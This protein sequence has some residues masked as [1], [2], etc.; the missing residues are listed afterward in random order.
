MTP[1]SETRRS[2]RVYGG[3]LSA[4]A[5]VLLGI[6][7]FAFRAATSH[8]GAGSR[9][10]RFSIINGTETLKVVSIE[11]GDGLYFLTLRNDSPKI[12]TGYAYRVAPQSDEGPILNGHVSEGIHIDPWGTA[13]DYL[14][15]P[16]YVHSRRPVLNILAVYFTDASGEGDERVVKE[17][18]DTE[19]GYD[20]LVGRVRPMVQELAAAPDRELWQALDDLAARIRNLPEPSE[21]ERSFSLKVG[22]RSCREMAAI[23][24]ERL[25]ANRQTTGLSAVKEK[26]A[27]VRE[28]YDK[29]WRHLT[30]VRETLTRGGDPKN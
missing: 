12:V 20:L 11:P 5:I 28:R 30:S 14:G 13:V 24:V 3:L 23:E 16:S 1:H 6:A 21:V 19:A 18:R 29:Q 4:A 26:I 27:Q 15:D 10:V 7:L 9:S 25:A 17:F 22:F 2:G 8:A